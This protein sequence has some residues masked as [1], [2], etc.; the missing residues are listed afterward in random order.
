VITAAPEGVFGWKWLSALVAV[1]IAAWW[2]VFL[3]VVPKQFKEYVE[4]ARGYYPKRE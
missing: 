3:V 1:P 4:T 2:Y